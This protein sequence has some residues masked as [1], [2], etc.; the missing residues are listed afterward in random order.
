MIKIKDA[1]S[2][3][4]HHK[5]V[6]Q[7]ADRHILMA[8]D[9]PMLV[10]IN[11]LKEHIFKGNT[12]DLYRACI[13]VERTALARCRPD[14]TNQNHFVISLTKNQLSFADLAQPHL[15]HSEHVS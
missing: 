8:V 11:G 2:K 1:I 15:Y 12:G 13:F 3:S 9:Y 5:V 10:F 7:Q 14:P 6:P 4:V